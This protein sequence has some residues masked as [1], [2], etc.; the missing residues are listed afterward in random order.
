MAAADTVVEETNVASTGSPGPQSSLGFL[1]PLGDPAVAVGVG[2]LNV[3]A[4][5]TRTVSDLLGAPGTG[6]AIVLIGAGIA[7]ALLL[8]GKRR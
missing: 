7:V 6:P 2:T 8:T 3:G 4:S 1:R 5:L